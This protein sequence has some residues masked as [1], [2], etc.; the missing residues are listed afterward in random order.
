MKRAYDY[1]FGANWVEQFRENY[2]VSTMSGARAFPS[3]VMFCERYG[4]ES[5]DKAFWWTQTPQG[6]NVW[7]N[8]HIKF[9][10]CQEYNETD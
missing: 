3:I 5:I 6:H 10:D 2:R 1:I 8:R 7:E 4:T 9:N